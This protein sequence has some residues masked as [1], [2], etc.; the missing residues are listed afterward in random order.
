MAR[1]KTAWDYLGEAAERAR[2]AR[3]SDFVAPLVE[4]VGQGQV[5]GV[6]GHG[7]DIVREDGRLIYLGGYDRP[8]SCVGAQLPAAE[9]SALLVAVHP[10]DDVEL[11]AGTVRV[12]RGG[13]E[14]ARVSLEGASVAALRVT[15]PLAREARRELARRIEGCELAN[16]VGLPWS[17]ELVEA[18]S[19]LCAGDAAALREAVLWLYGRGLGLTPSGDDILS[20][21]GCGLAAAGRR[22][23]RQALVAAIGEV[24]QRRST[25]Y[26]SEAYLA[27]MASG[28][29]NE[30][31]F[32]LVRDA[33]AGRFEAS[34]IRAARE[35]G[36][37]SG[38]DMLL[39]FGLALGA[40]LPGVT[41]RFDSP[42]LAVA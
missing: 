40:R 42:H 8:L 13:V 36:H 27:A 14:V 30:T 31:Y 39:G 23:R 28:R 41:A 21:F 9:L 2:G 19:G 24:S 12:L 33:R 11:G 37:T 20:G 18:L 6:H 7:L 17:D 32:D 34:R 4:Q 1:A 22:E 25:T 35:L 10:G 3:V 38:D 15:A 26:V 16:S 29:V 5:R